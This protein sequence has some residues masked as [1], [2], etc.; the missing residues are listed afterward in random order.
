MRENGIQIEYRGF[1]MSDKRTGPM[2]V[3]LP[4]DIKEWLKKKSKSN[5]RSTNAEITRILR[6]KKQEEEF[7]AA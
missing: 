5:D 2:S 7:K 3:R 6:E 4:D 1:F